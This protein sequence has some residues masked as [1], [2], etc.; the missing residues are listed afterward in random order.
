MRPLLLSLLLIASPP[1]S[2]A[3]HDS[4]AEA[5]FIT[6]DLDRF[7]ASWDAQGGPPDAATLQRDY[8]DPGS[9]GL[10][11]FV[12]AR[13]GDAD[14][15][16]AQIHALPG[17]Y[18]GLRPIAARVRDDEPKLRAALAQLAALHPTAR[19]PDVYF[20]IGRMN[21]GGTLT[22]EGLLIGVDMYGRDAGADLRGL[23][24]WHQAVVGRPQDLVHIVAHELIHYQQ[25][26]REGEPSLL[27]VAVGEGVADL[28]GEKISGRHINAAAHAW[29]LAN[30]CALWREFEPRAGGASLEGFLYEGEGARGRPADTGYFIGYRIGEAYVRQHGWSADSVAAL[31]GA[32]SAQALL[33]A[34]GYTPCSEAAG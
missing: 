26:R 11:A 23:S 3:L 21:S 12:G 24:R 22:D 5:R 2:A 9:T 8:L 16:A 6:A 7:W 20:L 29:G 10:R 15:L 13:I 30:E 4:P 17:Y 14:Q 18:A 27:D 1:L 25:Q 19:F 28:I 31:L 34:S 33:E 32:V